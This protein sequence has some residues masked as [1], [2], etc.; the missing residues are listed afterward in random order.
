MY[1]ST[2]RLFAALL[3]FQWLVAIAVA[4]LISPR[5]WAGGASR[6]HVHLWA[7]SLLGGAIISLPVA[8]AMLRPGRASTRHAVAVARR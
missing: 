5:T 4:Y 6:I 8:L 3:G 1:L 7:A 2:D